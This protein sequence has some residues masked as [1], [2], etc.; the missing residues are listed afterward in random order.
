MSMPAFNF[1]TGGRNADAAMNQIS[2]F[3]ARARTE[4]VGLQ[5]IR[6]VMFY[7]DPKTDREMMV[8][9]KG[10]PYKAGD[11]TN[12]DVYL[13]AGDED[14]L[15]LPRGI[16]IELARNEVT[17]TATTPPCARPMDISGS[18]RIHSSTNE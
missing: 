18:I 6:G 10:T 14:H 2:A 9:V 7:V 3:L 15:A 13:D 1:I 17:Y 5:E 4:A 12:V 16:G 8:L 11:S